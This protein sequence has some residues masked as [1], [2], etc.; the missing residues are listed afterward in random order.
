MTSKCPVCGSGACCGFSAPTERNDVL[1][2]HINFQDKFDEVT[3]AALQDAIHSSFGKGWTPRDCVLDA[4]QNNWSTLNAGER[5]IGNALDGWELG[6]RPVARAH[7][8][9]FV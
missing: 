4:I 9:C 3:D 5:L 2:D 7:A 6:G 8:K 1:R